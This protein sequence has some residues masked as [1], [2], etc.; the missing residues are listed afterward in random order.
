M[1]KAE[2]VG[3]EAA[4]QVRQFGGDRAVLQGDN[5][6]HDIDEALSGK[7]LSLALDFLGGAPVRDGNLAKVLHQECILRRAGVRTD[8][9]GLMSMVI[10]HGIWS[11]PDREKLLRV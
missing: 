4:E 11:S 3:P 10:G 5:L 7:K 2:L 9:C 1:S 6:R 8:V